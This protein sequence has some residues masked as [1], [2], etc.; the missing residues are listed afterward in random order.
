L[1]TNFTHRQEVPGGVFVFAGQT[2]ARSPS[3][4]AKVCKTFIGGSIPPR[5]SKICG[6]RK[7][8][9]DAETQGTRSC[10]EIL[11]A[12]VDPEGNF[13]QRG[14]AS[15]EAPSHYSLLT[16]DWLLFPNYGRSISFW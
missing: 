15:R 2:K 14:N 8:K 9:D 7:R 16:T 5:A 6:K 10:A 12:P 3:G 4:K 1:E 13:A 11:L